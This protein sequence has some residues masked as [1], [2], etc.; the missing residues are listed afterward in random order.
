MSD[1]IKKSK[2]SHADND[3]A[4]ARIHSLRRSLSVLG[5]VNQAILRHP[6]ISDLYQAACKIA[7]EKGDFER[8]YISRF[9]VETRDLDPVAHSN[10][11]PEYLDTIRRVNAG[12]PL[13]SPLLK[14]LQEG[15]YLY[16]N[17]TEEDPAME[18]WRNDLRQS[19]CRS[20]ATL[21]FIVEGHLRG[22]FTLFA[23]DPGYFGEE[24]LRLVNEIATDISSAI[25][26]A[27]Q[28]AELARHTRE[29][30]ESVIEINRARAVL[31]ESQARFRSIVDDQIDLVCRYDTELNLTFVN[32][33]YS[34]NH[35]STPEQLVGTCVLDLIPLED[36]D[37]ALQHVRALTAENPVAVSEHQ[38]LMPDG[39]RRWFQWTDRALLDENN[40]II[41]YQ[42]VGRDIS[43]RRRVEEA[44]RQQRQMAGALH[45]SLEALTSSLDVDT[46]MN[47]IL[48]QA[49]RVF[50]YDAA[51]ITQFDANSVNVRYNRG[52]SPEILETLTAFLNSLPS[53]AYF[54]SIRDGNPYLVTD[55]HT[56]P[57]WVILPQ[58][59]WVRSSLGVP[60]TIRGEIIGV[61][62]LDS[63]KVGNYTVA[64]I[65]P[66]KTFAGYAG[67]A[68]EN[69][70]HAAN[71]ER[72]VIERTAEV[73]REKERVEVILNNS[74]DGILLAQLDLT[75]ERENRVFSRLFACAPNEYIGRSLVDLVVPEQADRVWRLIRETAAANA[76]QTIEIIAQRKDG[77]RFDAELSIGYT[78]TKDSDRQSVICTIHD[79]SLLKERER[80]LRFH[81]SFQEN[82]TDGVI[83][84]T[85]DFRIQSWNRAAEMIFGW[86]AAEVI[87]KRIDEVLT[88]DANLLRKMRR[89]FREQGSWNGEVMQRRR[90]GRLIYVQVSL[91][92]FRDAY[93]EPLGVVSVNRD[94]TVRV[95][96]EQALRAKNEEERELQ[97]YL[98]NL[99]EI[100]MELTLIDDLDLFYRR[101][102]ELALEKFK[103]GGAALLLH[104]PKSLIALATYGTDAAGQ[105]ISEYGMEFDPTGYTQILL[106][107][108][109]QS[110]RFCYDEDVPLYR[111][112]E[113]AGQGWNAAAVMWNG[114]QTLGWITADNLASRSPATKAQL[115]ILGLY[116]STVGAILGQKQVETALRDSEQRFRLLLESAPIAIITSDSRG[117][118]T[119]ANKQA[120]SLFGYSAA[121]LIGQSVD[122][123]VPDSHRTK[124][125]ED[126]H[127]YVANPHHRAMA[128]D[129]IVYAM[130]RDGT[131]FPAQIELSHIETNAGIL[132]MS[133]IADITERIQA[134]AA[135][136]QQRVFLRR[137]IDV[138]P[139][140]IYV[141]DIEGRYV[142]ANP[143]FADLYSMSPDALIGKSY[144]DLNPAATNIEA[145]LE[146][147]RR[148]IASEET[149]DL[150]ESVPT[151]D[152]EIQWFQTTKV[153]IIG[154]DGISR[155]VLGVSTEI[156]ARKQAEEALRQALA[157]ETELGELKS[158]FVSIASHEFRTPLASILA[159]TETLSAYR[160]NM[161]DEQV[162]QRLG[163][164]REQVNHLTDI[165]DDV[166]HLARIQA[167][168]V[169]FNPIE[170]DIDGLC[171]DIL[172]E[173]QS[174]RDFNHV[175][176]Y[177]CQPNIPNP[178]LDKKLMRQVINNLVSNAIKYSQEMKPI[179]VTLSCD[180]SELRLEVTDE[181][182][183]IPEPDI[184]HLFEPFHRGQNV[185]MISGTGLGLAIIWES[186]SLHG[187][188]I[189]VQSEVGRGSTFVVSIP[190]MAEQ[191]G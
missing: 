104:D 131:L 172:D 143:M 55:T 73:T 28:S 163:K 65:E 32:A 16:S 156:T 78:G 64:D 167:R 186:V 41:E 136:E 45:E 134:A 166:L 124:H 53:N 84:T 159:A 87:G 5:E 175:L 81:A 126:R 144:A 35:A 14:L 119:L 38:T 52:F 17:D 190:L 110:G 9:D 158:R 20:W 21:P 139:S 140:I 97:T 169:Q 94:V 85:L 61:L 142:L 2:F 145:V 26:Y 120:Q 160:Q 178:R 91:V 154:E 82:V 165:M 146:A 57:N 50:S 43:E 177:T 90:D 184:K 138:S 179:R 173:F 69:A 113:I 19:G 185:G 111:Q 127:G 10:M 106:R 117:I 155:Y 152:G 170:L 25:A 176:V 107:A 44:E 162:E 151:P 68:L 27:E 49:A 161:A 62:S 92:I 168:R 125:V 34:K 183:G 6:N 36:R 115:E 121:E 148:V 141:K 75:I 66:M 128:N 116:A 30:E 70:Y 80:Q 58:L 99:H 109:Q 189:D 112:G 3:D 180:E 181:G 95:Q 100:G 98:K 132:V 11:S 13:E 15:K 4:E 77:T 7:V 31:A 23:R 79:I 29:L 96:A 147:D 42:G 135:L 54:T 149:I 153:P 12:I 33:A 105:V 187:G 51:S 114:T 101:A 63:R 191:G 122:V 171:R 130:R 8:A 150:E 37:R 157:K 133:F 59:E 103:F 89:E 1:V 118:I 83:A 102:V 22:T 86:N 67:L 24:E 164:I 182:I 71:L 48:E 56:A 108:F 174:Q 72:K 76:A 137:V 88:L 60:I 74:V 47:K 46:V 129:Q 188:R 123:L 40:R 93:G 39:T 18:R